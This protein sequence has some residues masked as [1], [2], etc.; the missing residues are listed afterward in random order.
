MDKSPTECRLLLPRVF[1]SSTRGTILLTTDASTG[2]IADRTGNVEPASPTGLPAA[3]RP[4]PAP[5]RNGPAPTQT[6]VPRVSG[7]EREVQ[8]LIYDLALLAARQC[9]Q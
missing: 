2:N 6:P 8:Q 7:R 4:V 5:P 3:H 9:P 1:T